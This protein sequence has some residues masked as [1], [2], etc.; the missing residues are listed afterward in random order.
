MNTLPHLLF[1]LTLLAAVGLLG[2]VILAPLLVATLSA[3]GVW[4]RIVALFADDATVR[5][6]ACACAI[7]LVATACVFFRQVVEPPTEA[8]KPKKEKKA[9]AAPKNVVGA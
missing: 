5:Q 6:T 2:L 8:P 7:G 3:D 1:R 4:Q 9:P